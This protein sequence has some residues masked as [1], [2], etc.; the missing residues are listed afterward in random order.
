MSFSSY[1]IGQLFCP[2]AF[3][4]KNVDIFQ[5]TLLYIEAVL[6]NLEEID[7]PRNKDIYNHNTRI[8]RSYN[9]P[10]HRTNSTP[11]SHHIRTFNIQLFTNYIKDMRG[12]TF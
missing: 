1:I 12:K 6:L 8:S 2:R 10:N 9:F 5:P 3:E 7:L 11:K 4:N